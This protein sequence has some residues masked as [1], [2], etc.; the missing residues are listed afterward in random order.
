MAL[1]YHS[2]TPAQQEEVL[3]KIIS[4]GLAQTVWGTNDL[5][6]ATKIINKQSA[7]GINPSKTRYFAHTWS[8]RETVA[9]PP[10]QAK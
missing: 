8:P 3:K 6:P 10:S 2:W 1:Q 7:N 9:N 4:S 5:V